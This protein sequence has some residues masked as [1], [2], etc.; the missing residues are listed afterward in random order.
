M[1]K[2]L[3]VK[4]KREAIPGGGTHY[5]YPPGYDPQKIQVVAYET[6][7][8][9]NVASVKSRGSHEFC[10]GVVKDADAPGFLASPDVTELSQAEAE[11]EALTWWKQE[12]V[13]VN[14]EEVLRLTAK[15]ARGIPLTP[16][17]AASLDPAVPGGAIQKTPTLA[18]RLD[19]AM[20]AV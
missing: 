6:S 10:I 11:A 2:V 18:K 14:P 8:A 5:V 1:A 12:D 13:V 20:K 17:E 4:I 15:A 19:D 7:N 9:D 16:Q 3:K